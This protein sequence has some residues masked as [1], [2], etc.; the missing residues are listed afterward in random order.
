MKNLWKNS[1]A[2]Q[3]VL[4]TTSTVSQCGQMAKLFLNIWAS[5]TT[6]T[7]PIASLFAKVGLK[8][9]QI[10]NETSKFA[11]DFI[12]F[13]KSGHT[14]RGPYLLTMTAKSFQF[15]FFVSFSDVR[16]RFYFRVYGVVYCRNYRPT[17]LRFQFSA[18]CCFYND[19]SSRQ[20]V[21]FILLL[22]VVV[23]RILS[24]KDI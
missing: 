9:C 6:K 12:I 8:F 20:F 21:A 7:Y 22:A 13:A 16:Q 15:L 11:Q 4:S 24:L 2:K 17:G 3:V 19:C 1:G 18:I 10:L 23:P 14:E 5:T